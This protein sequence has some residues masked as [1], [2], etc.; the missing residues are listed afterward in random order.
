LWIDLKR[1]K[2]NPMENCDHH[3]LESAKSCVA[4]KD[5]EGEHTL[6]PDK[7]LADALDWLWTYDND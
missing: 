3:E 1:L 5:H 2:W 4:T 7:A 6:V